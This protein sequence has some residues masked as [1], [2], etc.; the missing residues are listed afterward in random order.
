MREAASRGYFLTSR[1]PFGYRRIKVNDGMKER[2]TLEVDTAAAPVVREIFKR[3]LR[4]NGLKEIGKTLNARAS[5]TG[6]RAGPR[7][8]CT[9]CSPTRRTPAPPY[10]AGP[11]PA[12]GPRAGGSPAPCTARAPAP[13]RPAT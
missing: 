10:A 3:S 7:A 2:P 6:A 5:P 9:I 11:T 4:G 12:R 13:G 8:A 1:A